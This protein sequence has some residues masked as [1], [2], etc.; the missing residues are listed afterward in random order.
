MSGLYGGEALA[1]KAASLELKGL[2]SYFE[3]IDAENERN[4]HVPL[5]CAMD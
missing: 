3:F 4:L 1:Q 2:K 5:V